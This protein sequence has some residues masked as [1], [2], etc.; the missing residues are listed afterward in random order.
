MLYAIICT[1]KADGLALRMAHRSEHLAYLKSFGDGLVFAGP[2][3]KEDGKTMCGSLIVVEAPSL[4]AA[5]AIA[6][7]DPFSK[8][9]VFE[10]V[11]VRPWL[12]IMN[13]PEKG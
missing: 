4:D 10:K 8:L 11:E 12:W 6:A 5:R 7:G 3:L 9:G 2:F 1:D 13:K